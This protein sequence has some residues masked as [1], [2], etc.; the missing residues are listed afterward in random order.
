[1]K[2]ADVATVEA[3]DAT[4]VVE[5]DADAAETEDYLVVETA[6]VFG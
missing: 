2:D 4:E 3:V 5:T 6:V 1:M